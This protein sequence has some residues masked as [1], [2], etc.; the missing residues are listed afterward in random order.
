[1]NT[2]FLKSG[3]QIKT[4]KIVVFF[5]EYTHIIIMETKSFWQRVKVLIK[6]HNINQ[7]KF[8]EYIGLPVSTLK[9][10]IH[11]NRI[12]DIGTAID[13]ASA[14]GVSVYY[15]ALGKENDTTEDEKKKRSEVK[16]ASARI[17]TLHD[18]IKSDMDLISS[19]F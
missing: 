4:L 1:M 17:L 7:K 2:A 18:E 9:G 11:H 15:L 16:E 14:L 19:Y 13:I 3:I 6:A 8:A 10:W 12:P 5:G